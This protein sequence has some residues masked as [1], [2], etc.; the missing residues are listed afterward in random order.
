MKTRVLLLFLFAGTIIY[1]CKKDVA[2]PTVD[3]STST[4]RDIEGFFNA[5][6][7]SPSYSLY[8]TMDLDTHEYTF[9]TTGS[10][11]ICGFGYK[12]AG[13]NLVYEIKL[14]DQNNN[15]VYQGNHSFSDTTF[16]YI[17]I[18]PISISAGVYTLSRTLTNGSN[19]SDTIGPIT[20]GAN[21]SAISF[22]VNLGPNITITGS[23][24]YG[25]GGPVPNFG[26]P[27]I[28]FEYIEL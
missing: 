16:D 22:P 13:T 6:H 11:Q 8:E 25:G 2:D 20:R 4:N 1:S 26:I 27:N 9:N 24:F 10:L 7:S 28:Y 23:N 15:V 12:S 5:L 17:S 14:V 18:P 21:N 19:L 3:C